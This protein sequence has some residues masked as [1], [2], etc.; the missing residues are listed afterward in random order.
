MY[1]KRYLT[2]I[3]S[4]I[5]PSEMENHTFLT[6]LFYYR[7]VHYW[8]LYKQGQGL[9]GGINNQTIGNFDILVTVI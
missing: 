8:Q 7:N 5:F 4:N 1:F 3:F 6:D 9:C 2:I